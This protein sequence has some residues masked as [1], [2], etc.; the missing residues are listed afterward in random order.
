MLNAVTVAEKKLNRAR[1]KKLSIDARF[2]FVD[3]SREAVDYLKQ[4]LNRIGLAQKIGGSIQILEGRFEEKYSAICADIIGKARAGR[5]IFLLDQ[6]GYSQVPLSACRQI[7]STLPRSEIILTFAIDWLIDYL[8]ANVTFLKGV[9]PIELT[10]E[11]V[12]RYLQTKGQQG[13]RYL[14]QRLVIR[15][16]QLGTGA[17]YF[18]PFFLRSIEADR[19]LWLIHLSKHPTARNVMTS[20]HWAIQ[21]AS[22]HQG[23]AGLDMLGFDPNWEEALPLDFQ[24]DGNAEVQIANALQND[25]PDRVEALDSHG[26]ITF[27][28][29][30][31][32]IANDTAARIDQIEQALMTLH[33]HGDIEILTPS[34]LLKRPDAKLKSTDRIQLSQ[35]MILPGMKLP[36]KDE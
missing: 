11:Q 6:T 7:L 35:Q 15:A 22:I 24:F 32:A 17:P 9:A 2:Y 5:S 34:G 3:K 18:T 13:H 28:A 12:K 31:R 19:D 8:S 14:V 23:K 33:S 21:N 26:P 16:L 10:E 29:F 25:I 30:Q 1:R 20:S 36:A 27:D 4:E